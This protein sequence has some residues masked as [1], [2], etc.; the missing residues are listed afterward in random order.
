MS[1]DR[2][3]VFGV[4]TVRSPK[5][6]GMEQKPNDGVNPVGHFSAGWQGDPV[7]GEGRECPSVLTPVASR[8]TSSVCRS[9]PSPQ[10]TFIY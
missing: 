2:L 1:R 6:Q 9:A 8:M 10:E 7:Q 3:T 4:S 5:I